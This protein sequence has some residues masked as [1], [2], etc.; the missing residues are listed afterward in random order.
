M[1]YSCYF[2]WKQ[3]PKFD[4][5]R[6]HIAIHL[7]FI[8]WFILAPAFSKHI[9]HTHR[10]EQSWLNGKMKREYPQ[11]RKPFW[12]CFKNRV[13]TMLSMW[14]FNVS[15]PLFRWVAIAFYCLPANTLYNQVHYIINGWMTI[16]GESERAAQKKYVNER[17][18]ST[19]KEKS[20]LCMTAWAFNENSLLT[21]LTR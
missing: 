3:V 21:P 8:P 20:S 5:H 9:K 15:Y 1:K 13:C 2:K 10:H 17:K 4:V 7:Y 18:I 11:P 19:R 14:V 6:L 16:E 12:C